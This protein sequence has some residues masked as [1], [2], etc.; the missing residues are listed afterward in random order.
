MQVMVAPTEEMVAGVLDRRFDLALV[1][2]PF[3]T[4]ELGV[5]PLFEEE[6]VILRPSAKRMQGW[7]VGA[8]EPA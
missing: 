3:P 7:H 8:I 6:L 5:T 1:T 2:L 4:G